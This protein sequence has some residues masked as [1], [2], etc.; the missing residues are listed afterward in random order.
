[1]DIVNL[2]QVTNSEENPIFDF[3]QHEEATDLLFQLSEREEIQKMLGALEGMNERER[4]VVRL[5]YGLPDQEPQTL[6]KIGE[7]IGVTREGVRQIEIRTLQKLS[8]K[9]SYRS[10][11]NP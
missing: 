10:G 8:R 11:G 9:M 6:Q 1:M 5:R 2:K 3:H 7:Q 4:I